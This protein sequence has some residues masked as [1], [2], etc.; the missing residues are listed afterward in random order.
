MRTLYSPV[1]L[2]IDAYIQQRARTDAQ[3]GNISEKFRIKMEEY[4]SEN[5]K[6]MIF[7]EDLKNM[8]H[9]AT[10]D[11]ITLIIQMMNKF[12]EQNKQLRFGNFVFGPVVM[13][14]LHHLQKPAIALECFNSPKLEGFFEQ[15]ITYQLLLDLLYEH[16]M[17]KEMLTTYEKIQSRQIEGTKYPRNIIVL[18]MAAC[19]KLNT[20]DSCK[21]ALS[22][23]NCLKDAG[24][25]PMRR[26][27]TFCAALAV[28]HNQPEACIEILANTKNQNYTTV[29]NL[30]AIALTR[31]GRLDETVN[32]LKSVL[33]GEGNVK[34]TFNREVIEEVHAAVEKSGNASLLQE[35]NRIEKYFTEQGHIHEGSLDK[36]LCEEIKPPPFLTENNRQFTNRHN[37]YNQRS[38]QGNYRYN[39]YER[40]DGQQMRKQQRPGLSEMS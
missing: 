20:A 39:R 18:L 8:I 4:A 31:I 19:Y 24:H 14:M 35:L 9:L 7:T 32:L 34:Q 38:N 13:R 27:T 17:Y 33:E 15:L 26:A 12:N 5:S 2:G 40:D 6:N 1:T 25:F 29:R 36:Q 23:W 3:L 10:E 28:N 30:K 37:S 22:V 21:Y 16:K 11:D